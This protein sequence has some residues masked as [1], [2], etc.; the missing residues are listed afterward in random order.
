MSVHT[1]LDACRI[2]QNIAL[3]SDSIK[4]EL[5]NWNRTIFFDVRAGKKCCLKT[6][7]GTIEVITGECDNPDMTFKGLDGHI[8]NF[9]TGR[10]SY[11]SLEILGNIEYI[12][13]SISDKSHFIALVG[14]FM[15]ELMELF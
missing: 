15:S 9:L 2:Y 5:K 8:V 3:K 14:L 1:T 4:N 6:K 10:D 11:T 7:D 13:K 12:G